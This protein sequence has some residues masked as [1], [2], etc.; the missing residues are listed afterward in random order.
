[1]GI[2]AMFELESALRDWAANFRR[3]ETM[4]HADVDELEQH[5]R[6]SLAALTASGLSEEE[7]FL[8]ATHRVGPA[9]QLE[10]EFHKVNGNH[11]WGHRLLWM[12]AGYLLF[13]VSQLT[14]SAVAM[15]S[16]AV[17]AYAGGS[18]ATMG[19]AAVAVTACCWLALAVWICRYSGMQ[20]RELH[21]DAS[22]SRSLL[23][24]IGLAVLIMVIALLNV[25]SQFAVQMLASREAFAQSA[26]INAYANAFLSLL[27]PIVCVVSM[28]II[29]ARMRAGSTP[30]SL[31]S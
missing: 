28:L 26:V 16:Q 12:L 19:Y 3:T 21:G 10:R 11:V 27:L 22:K 15:F 4:R 31:G 6:D 9:A 25:G 30:A 24:P 18:G 7:A 8:V 20:Y 1:M 29:R 5:V 2:L 23:I 14:I 17:A 13:T